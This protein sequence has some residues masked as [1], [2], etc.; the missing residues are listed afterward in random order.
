MTHEDELASHGGQYDPRPV[1]LVKLPNQTT[2][3]RIDEPFHTVNTRKLFDALMAHQ[4]QTPAD[5][6]AWSHSAH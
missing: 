3:A 2:A 5:L 6:A 4:I 1:Y